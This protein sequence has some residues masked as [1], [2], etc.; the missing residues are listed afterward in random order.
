[1]NL[2]GTPDDEDIAFLDLYGP[3]ESP[4]PAVL[5]D[6]LAGFPEPWWLVGGHAIEAFT[7]ASRPHEDIDLVVF[8]RH[9]PQ[10]REH[11]RGRFHLWSQDGGTLRPLNDTFP[12]P[13][14]DRCQIWFRENARSPW[15]IDCPIN[16]DVD[17]LWQSKRFDDHVAPLDQVT[18]T[19]ERGIR[20]LNPEIVLH[21]KAASNREKDRHDLD[22]AWSLL[23]ET[24]RDWLRGAVK[25]YDPDHPW[26][27]RL[28][29]A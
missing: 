18:W 25:R 4:G 14:H 16:P 6:L 13:F 26:N 17:G 20:F 29:D 21:Y 7:G 22:Y 15:I 28:A 3:W 2:D 23:S 12:E 5:Q 11:F 8:S 24:Q 10:L 19:D 27:D 1:M 9:V